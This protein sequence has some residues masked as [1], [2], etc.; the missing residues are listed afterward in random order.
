MYNSLFNISE[1]R[2]MYAAAFFLTTSLL[3]IENHICRI[4]NNNLHFLYKNISII[5]I[6]VLFISL[7]C[8]IV[9]TSII[10]LL[11]SMSISKF[12]L[13][14]CNFFFEFLVANFNISDTCIYYVAYP[15]QWKKYCLVCV[16]FIELA[17]AMF[18]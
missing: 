17:R 11:L 3:N 13:S 8:I 9:S 12:R 6:G 10:Y 1:Y 15:R 7:R 14:S 16:L 4:F 18:N 5:S 2:L